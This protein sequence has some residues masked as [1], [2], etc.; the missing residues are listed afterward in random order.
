MKL[1]EIVGGGGRAPFRAHSGSASSL[2]NPAVVFGLAEHRLDHR[3]A[4]R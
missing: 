3:L 2:E 4:L 1:Q